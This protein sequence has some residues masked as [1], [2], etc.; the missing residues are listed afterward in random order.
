MLL[1]KP[2]LPAIHNNV[3][4]GTNVLGT[5]SSR[6]SL[7]LDLGVSSDDPCHGVQ[8]EA[9]AYHGVSGG[10]GVYVKL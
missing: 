10:E 6:S 7:Y 5:V 4:Q 3:V 9:P 2:I 1:D 8:H